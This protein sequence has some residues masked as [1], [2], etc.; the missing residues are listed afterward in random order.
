[1]S[2]RRF[3]G[4]VFWGQQVL[5]CSDAKK[6]FVFAAVLLHKVNLVML[7]VQKMKFTA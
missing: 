7:S 2:V 5:Q 6:Y 4:F 1:M 3:F